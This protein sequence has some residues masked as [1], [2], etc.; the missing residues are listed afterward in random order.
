MLAS[1]LPI[2]RGDVVLWLIPARL[3]NKQ[4]DYKPVPAAYNEVQ[5]WPYIAAARLICPHQRRT[6]ST[7]MDLLERADAASATAGLLCGMTVP[8]GAGRCRMHGEDGVRD[9]CGRITHV[10]GRHAA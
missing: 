2:R 1:P 7:R 10:R 5:I 8:G 6:P 9:V 4:I 3:S